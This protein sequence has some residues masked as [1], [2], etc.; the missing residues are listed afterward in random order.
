MVN[1]T[2]LIVDVVGR[3]LIDQYRR[4]Y[5]EREPDHTAAISAAT[6]LALERIGMSDAL[7]HNVEHTVM[8]TLVGTEILRGREI[9]E[10]LTPTDWLHMTVAL[11]CHDVGYVRGA[12]LKDTPTHVVADLEGTLKELP[13]GASDAW[14]TPFHVDRSKIFIHERAAVIGAIDPDRVAAAIEL[15]RFP[16]PDDGDHDATG[17]EA[18]LVRAADLIGQLADPGYLRK[19]TALFHEFVETGTAERL[20]YGS[21]AD[22]VEGYPRFFWERIEPYIG[23]G[24]RYLALTPE[25][26]Q[27]TA[28][29]YAHVFAV[30][31]LRWRMGPQSAAPIRPAPPA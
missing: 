19:L 22:L 4:V 26:R 31:H 8:V 20:G 3:H 30:E 15:T 7:Y 14:L 23:D 5:D 18:G 29:L 2:S 10:R 24:L 1:T 11:L 25:G 27:W 21:P 13:R 17:T 28:N 9:A 12:C 16:V 6:R